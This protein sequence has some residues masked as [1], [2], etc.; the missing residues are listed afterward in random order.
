[1]PTQHDDSPDQQRGVRLQT[2]TARHKSPAGRDDADNYDDDNDIDLLPRG[3]V[4]STES[5]D[6]VRNISA[7]VATRQERR[8]YEEAD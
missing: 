3:Y 8:R 7:R 4:V 1:M 5:S 6:H 2:L